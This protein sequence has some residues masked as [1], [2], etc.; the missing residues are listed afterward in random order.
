[1]Q[2]CND[3][4]KHKEIINCYS[5]SILKGKKKGEFRVELYLDKRETSEVF[6]VETEG[7]NPNRM[8]YGSVGTFL[9]DIG[10]KYN[11]KPLRI[12]FVG[13]GRKTYE[14]YPNIMSTCCF[15]IIN[16][17]YDCY[18]GIVYPNVVKMFYPKANMKH[19]LLV[20]PF[21]WD[22]DFYLE[23]DDCIVTWL[24]MLPISDSELDFITANGCEAFEDALEKSEVDILDLNR[25]AVI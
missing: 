16:S 5:N 15:H 18:P 1:M 23:M 24:E 8:Y 12:E 19:I 17:H 10:H 7:D 22:S 21:T 9:S 13:I 4:T 2:E 20:D 6:I 14:L 25:P 3:Y 11:N